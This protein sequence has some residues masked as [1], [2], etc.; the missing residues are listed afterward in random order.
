MTQAEL[1]SDLKALSV[2]IKALQIANSGELKAAQ[3]ELKSDLKALSV[4]VKALQI[5][6]SG[7]LKAAQAELKSDIKAVQ[8]LIW[9]NMFYLLNKCVNH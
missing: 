4:N 1:K 9:R 5:A 7:E 3:A 2:G 8:S 6:S